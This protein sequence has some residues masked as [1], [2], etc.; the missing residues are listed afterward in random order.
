[1]IEDLRLRLAAWIAPVKKN[2][3]IDHIAALANIDTLEAAIET[4]AEAMPNALAPLGDDI[5]ARKQMLRV[6][7]G[8]G[9]AIYS[10]DW[11]YHPTHCVV[12]TTQPNGRALLTIHDRTEFLQKG[13]Q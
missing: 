1:M 2:A 10:V 3:A 13:S 8:G 7:I 5:E 6:I 12:A 4:V 9:S 11:E